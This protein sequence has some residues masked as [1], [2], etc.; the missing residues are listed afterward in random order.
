MAR[1][2]ERIAAGLGV[3]VVCQVPHTGGGT[4]GMPWL[5]RIVQTI[6]ARLCART[7]PPPGKTDRR[8]LGAASQ[9]ADE[10]GHSP[11]A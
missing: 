10:R 1:T 9:G 11:A 2:V 7:R 5:A 3:K 4:F 8:E 6:Q